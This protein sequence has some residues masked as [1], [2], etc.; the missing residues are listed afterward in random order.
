MTVKARFS[1]CPRMTRPNADLFIVAFIKHVAEG[2]MH[3][4][5]SPMASCSSSLYIVPPV[6]LITLFEGAPDVTVHIAPCT[7]HRRLSSPRNDDCV[8]CCFNYV[9]LYTDFKYPP[10]VDKVDPLGCLFHLLVWTKLYYLNRPLRNC[11]N[12]QRYE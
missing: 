5:C 9:D 4:T 6:K 11:I 10:P 3:D 7:T 1:F 2:V 12:A 8:G